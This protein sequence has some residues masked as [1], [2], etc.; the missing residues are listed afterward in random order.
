[1]LETF[2]L[3]FRLISFLCQ[4]MNFSFELSTS[5]LT[6]KDDFPFMVKNFR[7]RMSKLKTCVSAQVDCDD[8]YIIFH[9]YF[10]Y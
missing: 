6:M 4:G 2:W 8:V 10:C 5:S 7:L 1:M 3:K 9:F